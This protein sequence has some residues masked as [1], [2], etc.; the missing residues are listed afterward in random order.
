MHRNERERKSSGPG[1]TRTVAPVFAPGPSNSESS[2]SLGGGVW[3]GR[4]RRH[5]ARS[6]LLSGRSP[7]RAAVVGGPSGSSGDRRCPWALQAPG[8]I[9]W[10]A[11]VQRKSTDRHGDRLWSRGG[12]GPRAMVQRAH[13]GEASAG[14]RRAK[15]VFSGLAAAVW[16]RGGVGEESRREDGSYGAALAIESWSRGSGVVSLEPILRARSLE[17]ASFDSWKSGRVGWRHVLRP[18]KRGEG[19]LG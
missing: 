19:E 18:T 13:L 8:Q 6:G 11:P 4:G 3:R 14:R 1:E 16:R 10:C 9:W 15:P 17:E 12:T 5:S 2:A 7:S